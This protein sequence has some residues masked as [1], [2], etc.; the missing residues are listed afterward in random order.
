MENMS[1]GKNSGKAVAAFLGASAALLSIG[2]LNV[3]T[4]VDAG[5]KKFLTFHSGI[6]PY[7]GKTWV[8]F[9][10]GFIVFAIAYF[11]LKDR[12]EL[13]VSTWLYVFIACLVIA[14]LL[15]FAPFLELVGLE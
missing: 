1:E 3:W 8:G 2:L 7:S 13:N 4:I 12:E 9:L 14:T 11:M 5:V 10:V 6:G 15:V